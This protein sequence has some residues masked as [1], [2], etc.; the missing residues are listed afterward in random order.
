MG[1]LRRLGITSSRRTLRAWGSYAAIGAACLLLSIASLALDTPGW[2]TVVLL[3][4]AIVMAG[5][6]RESRRRGKQPVS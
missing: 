2:A 1:I 5:L 3:V 4:A 6:A